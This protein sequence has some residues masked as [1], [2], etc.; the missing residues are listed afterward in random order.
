MLTA[1][2]MMIA[3]SFVTVQRTC[4][5]LIEKT[6]AAAEA[7]HTG[8]DAAAAIGELETAWES[9]C[10][11]LELFVQSQPLADLS[12]EISRLRPLYEAGSDGLDAEIAA[13]D[14]GLRRIRRQERTVF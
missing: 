13:I 8:S 7:V 3:V 4:T 14:A 5:A 2:L 9:G 6:Q 10:K 12:G 1:L 11:W